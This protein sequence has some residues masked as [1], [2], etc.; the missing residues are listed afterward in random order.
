MEGHAL[1]GAL[2]SGVVRPCADGTSHSPNRTGWESP[3]KLVEEAIPQLGSDP[4]V[5]LHSLTVGL[6]KD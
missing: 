6:A 1:P 3:R 5:I 4:M 2:R